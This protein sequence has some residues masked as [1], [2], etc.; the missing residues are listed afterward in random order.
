MRKKI[1][2]FV[3]ILMSLCIPVTAQHNNWDSLLLRLEE[4][5]KQTG[6][7]VE[8]IEKTHEYVDLGLS[9]K[10]ATCNIGA[11]APQDFGNFYAW[12]ETEPIT[13]R[14]I[15]NYKFCKGDHHSFTKYCADKENGYKHFTDNKTTLDLEDDVANVK[16]GGDWRIPTA[17]E[18]QELLD[19]CTWTLDSIN[20]VRGVRFTSNVPGYTDSSI[21]LPAAGG[22]GI[23]IVGSDSGDNK[24]G[25]NYIGNYWSSS[26]NNDKSDMA[27]GIG[28]IFSEGGF[29][30]SKKPVVVI[31]GCYREDRRSVRP[32]CP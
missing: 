24:K 1:L 8:R 14:N 3:S 13:K 4:F 28:Y 20:G 31:C 23:L 10:W 9:V 15:E 22:D 16:W 21:F 30:P 17:D 11:N 27:K 2:M 7:K 6:V 19:N 26:L 5:G 18:C 29:M 32:V 25:V 12:G